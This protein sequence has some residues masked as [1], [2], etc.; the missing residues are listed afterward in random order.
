MAAKS[1][2]HVAFKM[3]AA[4]S[5]R[6]AL[7]QIGR[8]ETV[9]GSPDDLSFG[10]INPP[11]ARSRWEWAEQWL[12]YDYEEVAQMADLFWA[13]A[14]SPETF[15]IVWV[16]RRDAQEHAGFLEFVW[17]MGGAAFDVVDVT[18]VEI[19]R[20]GRPGTFALSSLAIVSSDQIVANGLVERR[21]ALSLEEIDDCKA[22]WRLLRSEDAP[23]RVFDGRSLVSAPLTY[24]DDSLLSH[25]SDEWEKGAVVLGKTMAAFFAEPRRHHVSDFLLWGRVRALGEAGVLEIAGDPAEMRRTLVRRGKGS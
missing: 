9:I 24:F 15:P 25:V 18:D 14:T 13:E 21:R 1:T 11:S 23:L 8:R 22:R 5:L 12:G 17:R 7:R 19:H 4:G 16:S 6:I 2:I 20:P 10:P 3:S